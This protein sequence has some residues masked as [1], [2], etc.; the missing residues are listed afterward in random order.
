MQDVIIEE[1]YEFVPPRRGTILPR[2]L[3]NLLVPRQLRKNFGVVDSACSGGEKVRDA[4]AAG[5]G[6]LLTPNHSRPSDPM[7]LIYLA[8]A[9][10]SLLY[11]MASWHL[12]KQGWLQRFLIR[13]MGGFSIYREGMDRAALQCSMDILANAERPLVIFPEGAVSRTND[14]LNPL[15]EGTAAI[16]RGAARKRAER[17]GG[18]VFVFPVAFRY[19]F[20]GDIEATLTPV[21]SD[22]EKRLSWQPQKHLE[23]RERIRKVGRGL[24]GLKEVEYI[25]E[26]QPGDLFERAGRL[27]DHLLHPLENEWLGGNQ[28]GSVVARVKRLRAAI[29]KDM[30]AEDLPTAERDRRWQQ[31]S[32]L[33]FAQQLSLYPR[34]YL[35]GDPS[36]ERY[37]ETVERFEEDLDDA[38]RPHPPLKVAIDIC[39]GLEVSPERVR[40]PDPLMAAIEASLEQALGIDDA[41]RLARPADAAGSQ[42]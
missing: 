39:D 15:M 35:D 11:I 22:I 24:L 5:H 42:P 36:N 17:D 20:L 31:L 3:K 13:T 4:I 12:F 6:V 38:A 18:K 34:G 21:L 33:Y 28:D 10:D 32:A 1:P 23:L 25:G 14:L 2:L 30:V 16:A 8:D 41:E 7:A 37:L 9:I 27:I 26:T 40:G 29:L 19:H